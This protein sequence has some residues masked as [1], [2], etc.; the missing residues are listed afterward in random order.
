MAFIP[1]LF[2]N[3][4]ESLPSVADTGVN[5]NI[6][7]SGSAYLSAN[8]MIKAGVRDVH[9]FFVGSVATTGFDEI[10][11]GY[12]K[13]T[14]GSSTGFGALAFKQFRAATAKTADYTVLASDANTLFTNE[15][16]A[17]PVIFTLPATGG[18]T[19]LVTRFSFYA[20]DALQIE[21]R[22]NGTDHLIFA[23]NGSALD[24]TGGAATN[25]V[26]TQGE[27]LEVLYIGGT[28]WI[29]TANTRGWA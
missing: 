14:D 1:G 10:S 20:Y 26:A 25:N 24:I 29:A 4:G 12:G 8:G 7:P 27:Y 19:A 23:S 3:A 13:I 11:A 22:V 5:V 9:G 2:G 15:G 21:V 6:N 16:A 17:D 18:C 28:R